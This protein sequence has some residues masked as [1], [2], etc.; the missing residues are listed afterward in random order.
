MLIV[1]SFGAGVP[2][3]STLDINVL[4]FNL[5]LQFTN[6]IFGKTCLILVFQ[7][8]SL[9]RAVASSVFPIWSLFCHHPTLGLTLVFVLAQTRVAPYLLKLTVH[10]Q[11]NSLYLSDEFVFDRLL[12]RSPARTVVKRTHPCCARRQLQHWRTLEVDA[13]VVDVVEI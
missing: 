8:F 10:L 3:H 13:K 7:D 2:F 5:T 9:P 11:T 6:V 1:E 12:L 4:K